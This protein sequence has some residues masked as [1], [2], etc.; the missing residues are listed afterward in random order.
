MQKFLFFLFE[1]VFLVVWS[2]FWLK[3]SHVKH[4]FHFTSTG[5]R[6]LKICH[7]VSSSDLYRNVTLQYQFRVELSCL[8]IFI[9]TLQSM[10]HYLHLENRKSKLC[11]TCFYCFVMNSNFSSA[12]TWLKKRNELTILYQCFLQCFSVYV[13]QLLVDVNFQ[14][15]TRKLKIISFHLLLN[16]ASIAKQLNSTLKKKNNLVKICK[17]LPT[18]T[19]LNVNIL[20]SKQNTE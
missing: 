20:K 3:N 8:P 10:P 18:P 15:L 9:S 19:I 14:L 13:I 4:L 17:A 11:C 5:C 6:D 12:V 1:S 2:A 16:A 7:S